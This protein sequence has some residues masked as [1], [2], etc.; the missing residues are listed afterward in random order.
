M[1]MTI[2]WEYFF[3]DVSLHPRDRYANWSK[4]ELSKIQDEDGFWSPQK[5]F[6]LHMQKLKVH[7]KYFEEK[8]IGL[9][10]IDFSR[11]LYSI[12]RFEEARV[13]LLHRVRITEGTGVGGYEI[14]VDEDGED[15]DADIFTYRIVLDDIEESVEVVPGTISSD[16][17]YRCRRKRNVVPVHRF[18]GI[19]ILYDW[20]LSL[21][22]RGA[23]NNN[24]WQVFAYGISEYDQTFTS[25]DTFVPKE[26]IQQALPGL[27]MVNETTII[28]QSIRVD[29]ERL[30]PH[31]QDAYDVRSYLKN[32]N[33]FL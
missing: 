9:F 31:A 24:H 6:E 4:E 27:G 11:P 33:P 23:C 15:Y 28:S 8:N 21:I 29:S 16:N 30:C 10:P 7:P 5:D 18:N 25:V 13:E 3:P 26:Q 20:L 12:E 1:G 32:W 17:Q 2:E 22:P 19:Y 14:D